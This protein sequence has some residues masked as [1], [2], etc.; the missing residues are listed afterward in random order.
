VKNG[1]C[2]GIEEYY[3][4]LWI[5]WID[6]IAY[7]RAVGQVTKEAWQAGDRE[8]IDVKLG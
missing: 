4:V 1:V 6:G 2:D 3:N 5:E 8:L 7:R